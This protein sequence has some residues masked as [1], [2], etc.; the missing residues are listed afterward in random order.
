MNKVS[1]RYWI[2]R[3]RRVCMNFRRS[4]SE[5]VYGQTKLFVENYGLDNFYF[6]LSEK[7]LRQNC[8]N[9]NSIGKKLYFEPKFGNGILGEEILSYLVL[10]TS[11]LFEESI[12]CKLR[13]LG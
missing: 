8:T 10:N 13:I 5:Q 11:N 7:Q 6:L 2:T 3:V 9:L 1:V 4:E 12:V